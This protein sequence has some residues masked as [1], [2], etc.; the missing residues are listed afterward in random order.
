MLVVFVSAGSLFAQTVVTG[1]VTSARDGSALEGATVLVKGTTTGTFTDDNGK[2]SISVPNTNATLVVSFLGFARIEVPLDGRTTVDISLESEFSLEE[3]VVTGY[4]TQKAKEVTSAIVSVKAENFNRGLVNDPSQ[5]IQGKVAGLSISRTGSDPNAGFAIR[6]RGLSTLG[7]NEQPLVIIDGV[8][9]ASLRSVDPNDIQSMDVLKDGSAA[10]IYGTQAASG[11]VIITTKKGLPGTSRVEYTATAT[12]EQIAKRVSV[13]DAAEFVATGGPNR[14]TETDWVDEV[15][16]DARSTVHNV[17]LTGGT[18]TTSYRVSLNYR[19]VQGILLKNGFNQLNGRVNLTQKALN[20]KL[21]ITTNLS[22]TERNAQYGMRDA[23][24]YAN[25]Y[26]P[27]APVFADANSALGIKY[28]GFY[29]EENFDYFNPVAIV[30]QNE[31]DGKF[32]NLLASIRGDYEII[33]GLK[34]SATYSVQRENTFNGRYSQKRAYYGGGFN[35]NG[36]ATRTNDESTNTLFEGTVNYEKQFGNINVDVLAGYSY[37][38]YLFEGFGAEGGDFLSD[39]LTYNNLGAARD[40]S[41][42]LGN[43]FSYKNGYA[44]ESVFGRVRFNIDDTYFIMAS[45]RNDGSTR[46]GANNKRATFPGVSVGINVANLVDIAALDQ[47]KVRAG[48]GQT[49]NLPR[50]S[51]Q[52]LQLFQR[53]S[54]F[55]YNGEF[56]PAYGPAFNP[57]PDLRWEIKDEIN[58]GVD[59]S[60]FGNKLSGSID[61]YTRTTTDLI[62][63]VTVPVPPNQANR[64]IAN[65]EDVAL[66]NSGV[67]IAIGT[68]IKS[69][70]FSYDPRLLF[71]TFNTIIDTLSVENPTF[72]FFKSGGQQFDESTSPGAPGLNN[73]PT[74]V[75]EAGGPLGQIWGYEHSGFA[76]GDHTFVDQDPDGDGPLEPDG[77]IDAKDQ[78]V[79]GNG[80]PD[81]SLGFN[82]TFKYKSLDL[83]FFLRGDFG[84]DL[85]NMYRVFYESLGSRPGDNNVN[86]E[87]FTEEYTAPPSK[88]SSYY[89]EDAS[90]VTLDNATL[91]YNLKL[92]A[93]QAANARIF[94]SGQNLFVITN[95]TGPDPSVRFADPGETDNGALPPLGNN[96]LAPGLD[97]RSTYFRARSFT[98]GLSL[99][100]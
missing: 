45:L 75:V 52:S 78:K 58:A 35:R 69:G 93:E 57:N 29:Q 22:A 42:G 55:F 25:L 96:V 73:L 39:A 13:M 67:E 65:L 34:V 79:I 63:N 2:Y 18:R 66:R 90:F 21:T 77:V 59:F 72:Q 56:V 23:L 85:V 83:S 43:V 76:N 95:Y 37:Q 80:L 74:V 46:F 91:G 30:E 50:D 3:V 84:H 51:Y 24:R 82:N 48:Y 8:P 92:G 71:S 70:D 33:E 41:E 7:Q 44:L 38:E 36:F 81:F 100:F 26:N 60:F 99:D 87:Y 16:R 97:R 62:F 10:A 94:V 98:V 68:S 1:T 17:S 47:L 9:G 32:K 28:G 49:G 15:T 19:G 86:T 54:N 88:F 14:G 6:L 40:F 61:Y 89:V 4:G 12:I 64:T 27:T 20:E 11:V 5:L 31:N 53:V